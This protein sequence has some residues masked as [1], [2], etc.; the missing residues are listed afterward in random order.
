M[1]AR[2]EAAYLDGCLSSL[3][4]QVNE[5]VLVDTGSTDD[6]CAIALSHGCKVLHHR[7]QNDFSVARNFAVEQA[8]CTWILYIDAD[9]RLSSGTG[10]SLRSLLPGDGYAASM[11]KF[12][13]RSDMTCYGELRLFRNDPRIRF[14][15]A[16]HETIVPAID[17]VRAADGV[18]IAFVEDLL[19]NHL[20]YEGDQTHKHAR[21]IPLLEAALKSNPDR[22]YLHYHLGATLA[23]INQPQKAARA[24]KTAMKLAN[25]ASAQARVEGSMSAQILASLYLA[26]EKPEN[27]MTAV[28]EGLSL[29]AD[30]LALH[31]LKARSYVA[32]GEC[33][34]AMSAL[35]PV[36]RHVGEDF[37][38]IRIAYQK[39]LFED[40]CYGVL[41]SAHFKSGNYTDAA[42]CFDKALTYSPDSL[43][44]KA[45]KALCESRSNQ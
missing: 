44:Y 30:N 35:E 23:E 5:I 38:D 3:R 12:R 17:R 36:L 24:L 19:V 9:E 25:E 40:A 15:G 10:Q 14:T 39:N 26:A 41:G 13:P 16:M 37:F 29:F 42:R 6:T 27:A 22:V 31:W 43:E 28:I 45:K 20:G 21:N 33:Q 2:N 32:F 1:I 4:G 11:V 7:W 34:K 8:S 18:D